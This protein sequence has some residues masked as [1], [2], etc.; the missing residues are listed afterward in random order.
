MTAKVATD[1]GTGGS[2]SASTGKGRSYNKI[3]LTLFIVILVLFGLLAGLYVVNQRVTVQNRADEII[4][5]PYIEC[6]WEGREGK[7]YSYRIYESEPGPEGEEKVVASGTGLPA[8]YDNPQPGKLYRCEV[9]E[10]GEYCGENA[11]HFSVSQ[12]TLTETPTETPMETTPEVSGP[13]TPS[14]TPPSVT[15]EE[16]TPSVTGGDGSGEEAATPTDAEGTPTEAEATSTPGS[17]GGGGT[18]S[19]SPTDTPTPTD[20]TSGG[21]G[22]SETATSTPTDTVTSGAGTTAPT[23]VDDDDGETVTATAT[24]SPPVSGLP[25]ISYLL[26]IGGVAVIAAGLFLNERRS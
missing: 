11:Y 26:L 13:D 3:I 14:D 9:Y 2:K 1:T 7:S 18:G 23:S 25:G 17:G 24:L 8:R 16:V 22:D 19:S 15:P 21:D 10:D 4:E 20:V 5:Q 12:V 6:V